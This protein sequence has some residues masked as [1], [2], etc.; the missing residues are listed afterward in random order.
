HYNASH[1]LGH[2][3]LPASIVCLD[4]A[5]GTRKWHF[6]FAH[7]GLW[8]YDPPAAPVLA[9]ITVDRRRIGGVVRVTK[10]VLAFVFH[11]IRGPPVWPIVERPVP[12]SDVEGEQASP[13]QPFPT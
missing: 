12:A 9:T 11:R 8:D 7:H 5:T 10:Q 4:A 13:T 2:N 1:S 6:Q 3:L